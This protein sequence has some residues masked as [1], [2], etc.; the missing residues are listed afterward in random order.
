MDF[1]WTD[2]QTAFRERLQ[3]IIARALPADWGEKSRYDTSSAYMSEF[4]RTFCPMLASEGLLIPHW[5]VELGGGG[6]DPFH[7]W[8]LGEE[9]FYVGDPRSYQYMN[10]NWVGP[11]IIQYGTDAQRREHIGRIAS[12]TTIWCQGFSE[13]SA[14][15]DLAALSTRAERRGDGYVLNGSKIWTSGASLADYCFLLA[16]TGGPG[17][18]GI[19]VFLLPTKMPGIEIRVVPSFMGQ[20][21]FHEVFL[22][23]VQVPAE[24][25]L[26]EENKGWTIVRSVLHNE[27]IGQPRYMLSM[28]VLEHAMGLL[29]ARG[30]DTELARARAAQAQAGLEAARYLALGVIDRRAK[31]LPVDTSTNIARYAL[32]TADRLVAD[33][34]CDFLHD[35]VT[36]DIDP[37]ISVGFR[38]T[39]STGLA[40]GSAEIQ[41]NLISKH[42]LQ[43][44]AVA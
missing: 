32:V 2:E 4:S 19:S 17:T 30:E 16:R 11:A 9:M 33:F 5:P 27:R 31:K 10:V 28:R 38:R 1:S 35:D 41:L 13:P 14:G 22:T 25:R 7:H 34:L 36:A 8:I 23:D 15:S 44:P 21:S 42:H 39:G 6:M 29:V 18:H 3:G 20:Y 40:A 37:L 43:L 24:M 12:G 26:G